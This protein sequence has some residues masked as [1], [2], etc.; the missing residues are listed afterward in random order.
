MA[1]TESSEEI[2]RNHDDTAP[3]AVE[4]PF[5][6][7]RAELAAVLASDA[8]RRSN[9][10]CAILTIICERHFAGEQ[11]TSEYHIALDA[12]HRGDDFNPIEDATVRVNVHNLRKKLREFYKSEGQHHPL[13][14]QIPSGHYLPKFIRTA[15]QES[16]ARAAIEADLPSPSNAVQPVDELPPE[17]KPISDVKVEDKPLARARLAWLISLGLATLTLSGVLVWRSHLAGKETRAR[18]VAPLEAAPTSAGDAGVIRIAVGSSV[19]FQ[20]SLGRLWGADRWATGGKAFNRTKHAIARTADQRLFQSGREGLFSYDIPLPPGVY[21]L[22][23]YFADT[24]PHEEVEDMF[25]EGINGPPNSKLDIIVDAGGPDTATAKVYLDVHPASDGKLHLAFAPDATQAFLNAIEIV[26][27]TPGKMHPIWQTTL[28]SPF[29]DHTGNLWLPDQWSLGGRVAQRSVRMGNT[30]DPQLFTT[31][32]YG[33]F[34]YAIPVAEHHRYAVTLFFSEVWYRLLPSP[35][36][37][38]RVFD[39]SCNGIRLLKNFDILK[40]SGFRNEPVVRSFS[41]IESSPEGKI[42]LSFDPS[43]N[44]ALINAIQ[45]ED[46]GVTK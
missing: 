26:P 13:H 4:D 17:E 44:Y 19:P 15:E 25:R 46:E 21:E 39:V 30:A 31:E 18:I 14:I 23:L 10:L 43:I 7:E 2:S 38:L 12:L 35:H 27:G 20:D 36:E 1:T 24:A 33:R 8:L 22:H 16:P 5:F 29:F 37:G 40:E 32:R 3:Q 11:Y 42:F 28:A 34:T 9:N 41:H 6:E 45:I